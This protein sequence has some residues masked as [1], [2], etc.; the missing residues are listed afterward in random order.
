MRFQIE[1]IR[2]CKFGIEYENKA[3]SKG[4]NQREVSKSKIEAEFVNYKEKTRSRKT[5]IF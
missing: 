1:N 5:F 2:L 3:S 4:V